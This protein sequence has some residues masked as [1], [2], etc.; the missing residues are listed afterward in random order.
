MLKFL[1]KSA[2]LVGA[3]GLILEGLKALEEDQKK[4]SGDSIP[5]KPVSS[6][7]APLQQKTSRP[8]D[9]EGVEV[10]DLALIQDESSTQEHEA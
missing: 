4:D 9:E 3:T 5:V 6:S 10:K 8:S 1:L 7:Q 2:V